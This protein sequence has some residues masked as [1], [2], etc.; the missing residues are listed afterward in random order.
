M[1]DFFLGGSRKRKTR[2]HRD[3]LFVC[4]FSVFRRIGVTCR[5]SNHDRHKTHLGAISLVLLKHSF[6]GVRGD[7]LRTTIL[8]IGVPGESIFL[9]GTIPMEGAQKAAKLWPPEPSGESDGSNIMP[10]QAQSRLEPIVILFSTSNTYP[11][12]NRENAKKSNREGG[13][14]FVLAP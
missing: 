11:T 8:K 1:V 6:D 13:A 2:H 7:P 14:S 12:K 3:W 9:G 5:K 4:H 10:N